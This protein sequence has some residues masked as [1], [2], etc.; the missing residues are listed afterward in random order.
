MRIASVN[1]DSGISPKRSK[2]AAVHLQAMRSAFAQVGCQV[3]A[4]DTPDPEQLLQMLDERPGRSYGMVY[5]RY[6]LGRDEAA[7]YA[8]RNGVPYVVEI[9]APLADEAARYRDQQE[10]A[11]D[12]EKD[13]FLFRQADCVLAVSSQVA[14]YARGRGARP[15]RILVRPNGIDVDR[16]N[17]RVDGSAVRSLNVPPG[18]TVLGFHGR[19]RPWHGF[20]M[21]ISSFQ[22]L[23]ERRLPV[24]LMVVGNGSFEA[25]SGLPRD[26]YSRV[27]W[28][29]HEDIPA[30]VAAFDILPL[31]YG[32][33]VP[34]YFSPLKLMEAMACGVVPVVPDLGDLGAIVEHE[35]NGVVYPAGD[36]GALVEALAQLVDDAG[37]R[38]QLGARAARDARAHTWSDI[39]RSV[40]ERIVAD[41]G[42]ERE[43]GR[44]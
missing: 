24:H 2:G 40:L 44:R 1:Q 20:D 33:G 9:N 41:P 19:E 34:F 17:D 6:A 21:L 10:T 43:A 29:P 35:V 37:L 25:L 3:E 31:T 4:L 16:F 32:T 18:K 36:A 23:L 27:G 11:A 12:R 5:E 42:A 39:A 13:Q 7:R 22:Q 26:S 30:F 14:E 15:D 8:A 28:Q 38:R